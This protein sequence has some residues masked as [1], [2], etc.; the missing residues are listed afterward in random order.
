MPYV[1]CEP[2]IGVK[3]MACKDM[4]P[5]DCIYE[6]KADR[7]GEFPDMLFID[8]NECIDCNI[9]E[10]ECPVEAIFPDADVPD[11]WKGYIELNRR[12]FEVA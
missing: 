10:P 6:R 9:C 12:H 11:E 3:D 2:C 8:P 1:I 5:V 4:C 7:A